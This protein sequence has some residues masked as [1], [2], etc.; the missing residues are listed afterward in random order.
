M[1]QLHSVYVF[2]NSMYHLSSDVNIYSIAVASIYL[3]TKC[4]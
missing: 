4:D 2:I 3:V 1:V